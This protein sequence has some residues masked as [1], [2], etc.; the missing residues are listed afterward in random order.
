MLHERESTCADITTASS[1][2]K[3]SAEDKNKLKDLSNIDVGFVAKNSV[4]VKKKSRN[5]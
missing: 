5:Q 1:M 3:I 2:S 4:T